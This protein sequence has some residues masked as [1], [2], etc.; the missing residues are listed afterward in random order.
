MS[1]QQKFSQSRAW[2]CALLCVALSACAGGPPAADGHYHARGVV[3]AISGSGS[4]A[5]LAIHHE[6]I[7]HFKDRD[8]HATTMASMTM[9][10]GLAEP[11][12]Q[13]GLRVGDKL[14]FEFDL[15]WNARPVL[16]ITKLEKLPADTPLTL[17][18]E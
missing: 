15:R 9:I 17:S 13:A 5:E 8:G 16:L 14:A 1:Y 4:D 18:G 11:A 2:T 3:A 7:A 10:F 6:A 12:A